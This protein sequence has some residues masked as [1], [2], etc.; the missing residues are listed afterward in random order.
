MTRLDAP[1]DPADLWLDTGPGRASPSR[2]LMQ[3]DVILTGVGPVCVCSHACSMRRGAQFHDTQIVAPT[4]DHDVPRWHGSF[5]WMPLPGAPLPGI[6]NPAAC[7][8]EL[9]SERTAELQAGER[10]AVM[11][12]AGVHLLQQRIA[13]HLSRVIIGLR[14]L[15]E[16]SAPVLAE[17]ELHEEWVETLGKAAERELHQLLE[18]NDRKLRRWLNEP[19]TRPQAMRA[20]R[21][22][23]RRRRDS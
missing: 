21:Q 12:D 3:G 20:V 1:D 8:R 6:T 13:H 15:A 22:E 10:V 4:Q 2:P 16:H 11:A 17:V 5:D 19:R 7:I 23:I 14:E 9:R 18:E